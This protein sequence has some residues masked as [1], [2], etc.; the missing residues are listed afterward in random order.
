MTETP[1]EQQSPSRAW[2]ILPMLFG[3]LGGFVSLAA[4]WDRDRSM[5][6]R[7]FLAG[8]AFSIMWFGVAM[9][10]IYGTGREIV[11]W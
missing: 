6:Y 4:L 3:L 1:Q 11:V 2:F 5:A 10:L 7:S 9:L 8:I